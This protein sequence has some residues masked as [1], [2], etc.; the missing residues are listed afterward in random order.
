MRKKRLNGDPENKLDVNVCGRREG[1]GRR[2]KAEG[3]TCVN[4]QRW[5][6]A[7]QVEAQKQNQCGW[8]AVLMGQSALETTEAGACWPRR[9]ARSLGFGG[10]GRSASWF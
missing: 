5:E 8:T 7:R 1:I 3:T 10:Q 6:E 4:S 9:P 2:F